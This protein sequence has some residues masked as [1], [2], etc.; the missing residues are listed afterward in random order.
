MRRIA[1]QAVPG[2][3]AGAVSVPVVLLASYCVFLACPIIPVASVLLMVVE[4][5]VGGAVGALVMRRL[6]AGVPAAIGWVL[7]ALII[8]NALHML[9]TGT[10][11]SLLSMAGVINMI[12]QWSVIGLVIYAGVR[13]LQPVI[14]GLTAG[15]RAVAQ[16]AAGFASPGSDPMLRRVLL[17]LA[18]AATILTILIPPWTASGSGNTRTEYGF[19]IAPPDTERACRQ[20]QEMSTG[21]SGRPLVPIS[22]GIDF[23]RVA[24]QLAIIWIVYFGVA[25]VLFRTKAATST[26]TEKP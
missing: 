25:F 6:P 1:L 12:V 14:G 19:I 7:Y 24:M 4:G 23:G 13:L 17:G 22:C 2:A 10:S 9:L 5:A 8:L 15:P 26:G 18:V 16:P 20:L 3:V 21:R 11:L